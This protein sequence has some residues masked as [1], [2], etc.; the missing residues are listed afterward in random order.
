MLMFL[1]VTQCY[2]RSI[3]VYPRL[4]RNTINLLNDLL[5]MCSTLSLFNQLALIA[6]NVYK[7]Y[8]KIQNLKI[9]T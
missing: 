9:E 8:A 3:H 5:M 4:F 6:V 1:Y 2:E 7:D